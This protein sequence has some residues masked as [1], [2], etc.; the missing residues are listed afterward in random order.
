L[1]IGYVERMAHGY[2]GHGT[3]RNRL[4]RLGCSDW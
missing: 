1:G 2:N 4:Y 3:S